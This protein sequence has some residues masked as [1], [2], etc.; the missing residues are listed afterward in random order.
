MLLRNLTDNVCSIQVAED[1]MTAHV[2]SGTH[3]SPATSG[4]IESNILTDIVCFTHEAAVDVI[5]SVPS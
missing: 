3:P 4:D 2:P 5:V 1:D